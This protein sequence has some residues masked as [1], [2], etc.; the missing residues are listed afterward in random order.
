MVDDFSEK[1][2]NLIKDQEFLLSKN[3]LSQKIVSKLSETRDVLTGLLDNVTFEFPVGT[4]LKSGKISKGENYGGLPYFVL[5]YPAFFAS[6]DVFAYRTIIWWGNEISFTLFLQG[7]SLLN[8]QN[9]I[10]K[11]KSKLENY[12]L[13]VNQTPWEHDFGSEN[14]QLISGLEKAR[15]EQVVKKKDF[16]KLSVPYSLESI[17]DLSKKAE[18]HLRF[19]LDLLK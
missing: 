15:Y 18:L 14:Y 2:L 3:T 5:D 1:E 7:S 17:S 19:L 13:C 8:H 10:L 11:G 9:A 4:K 6:D 12:Y 16:I